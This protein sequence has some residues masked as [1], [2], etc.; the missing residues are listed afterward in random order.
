MGV[1]NNRTNIEYSV[2]GQTTTS[3]QEA[4]R[5]VRM[6]E[7]KANATR[8]AQNAALREA[9]ERKYQADR[10]TT[11]FQQIRGGDIIRLEE[12]INTL[13]AQPWMNQTGLL[14]QKAELA[15]ASR[16][17]DAYRRKKNPTTADEQKLE[18]AIRSYQRVMSFLQSL[19]GK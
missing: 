14:A 15:S 5:L 19:Q 2:G 17:I 6:Q 9:E 18:F 16:I 13:L 8:Q 7:Q 10:K 3:R 11:V 1:T 4:E 12:E